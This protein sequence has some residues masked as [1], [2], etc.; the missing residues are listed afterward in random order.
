MTSGAVLLLHAPR[1]GGTGCFSDCNWKPD[2][3]I[4]CTVTVIPAFYEGTGI[5][6]AAVALL[7]TVVTGAF[8]YR[9][10]PEREAAS[11][12]GSAPRQSA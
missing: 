5:L 2:R 11:G 1:R 9:E 7:T 3:A 12:S 10:V 4:E 8:I 6:T